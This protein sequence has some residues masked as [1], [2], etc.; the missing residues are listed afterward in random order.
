MGTT[1][2]G[3]GPIQDARGLLKKLE[4]DLLRL[5]AG[6]F[7]AFASFD[8]FLTAEH[9]PEWIAQG[10]DA[11]AKSIRTA[12]GQMLRVVSHLANGAKHFHATAPRHDSVQSLE[13]TSYCA[14]DY[15]D[16]YF[17]E[18]VLLLHLEPGQEIDAGKSSI[19]PY[20][21]AQRVYDYWAAHPELQE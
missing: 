17:E 11:K 10:D 6:P 2:K 15:A 1:H 18:G 8:F 14:D 7:D 13:D 19:S 4:H 20:E 12:G 9:L 16:D 3:Y 21:L 5:Q